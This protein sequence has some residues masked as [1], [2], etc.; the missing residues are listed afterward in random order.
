MFFVIF[1]ICD[2]TE[3]HF[4]DFNVLN[5]N[6]YS[7]LSCDYLFSWNDFF[8]LFSHLWFKNGGGIFLAWCHPMF[9]AAICIRHVKFIFLDFFILTFPL[10][11][12]W[13]VFEQS[14][15]LWI[16]YWTF[17][18]SSNRH[19][20]LFSY[21]SDSVGIFMACYWRRASWRWSLKRFAW[22]IWSSSFLSLF[23]PSVL[24]LSKLPLIE[25]P[26]VEHSIHFLFTITGS[27]VTFLIQR[28]V[29]S[30]ELAWK[31]FS[32]DLREAHEV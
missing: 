21:C 25:L 12:Y 3:R 16:A 22:S 10:M 26:V 24:S 7:P 19:H 29:S 1:G 18:P 17:F 30:G 15:T 4:I 11:N 20:Q 6:L 28:G 8:V 9:F 31:F 2:I 27:I 23:Y 32:W 13:I 14:V 5:S